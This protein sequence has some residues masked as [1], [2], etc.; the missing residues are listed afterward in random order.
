[1]PVLL[2]RSEPHHITRP[3][4]LNRSAF[5]L[6]PATASG[7]DEDL[8]ERMRMPCRSGA[9][10]KRDTGAKCACR[11]SRFE[12]RINAHGAG[13]I[14]GWTFAGRLRTNSLYFHFP[15]SFHSAAKVS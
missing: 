15:T 5:A 11:S 10:F 2:T 14:I 3:D 13:E 4:F 12:Q 1:M 9:G 6:D 7:H 8:A